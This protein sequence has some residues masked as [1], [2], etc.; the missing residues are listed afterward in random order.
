MILMAVAMGCVGLPDSG[1]TGQAHHVSISDQNISPKD[2]TVQSGDE[3][4]FSNSGSTRVWVYFAN[5]HWNALSCRRGFSYFWGNEESAA[6][7]PNASVSLCFDTGNLWILG[8][9]A[10]NGPWRRSTRPVIEARC[11][12]RGHHRD[13]RSAIIAMLILM[14]P[15]I[16]SYTPTYC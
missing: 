7:Q 11:N 9:T 6:V 15:M 16:S 10:S 4:L 14:E 12:A 1:R 8:T 2:L 5:D 13:T 3:I